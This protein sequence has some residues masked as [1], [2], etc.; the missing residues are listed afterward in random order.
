MSSCHAGS[1][2]SGNSRNSRKPSRSSGRASSKQ[3]VKLINNCQ[4]CKT[5]HF[6][7]QCPAWNKSCAD[8]GRPNVRVHAAIE[9]Q[10]QEQSPEQPRSAS[11][12]QQLPDGSSWTFKYHVPTPTPEQQIH[13]VKALL[14][15]N[16][17]FRSPIANIG[18]NPIK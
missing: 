13:D 17:Q 3:Q 1:G 12:T 5:S 15:E 16:G 14:S 7:R 10:A 6:I 18:I 8:C 4:R 11:N 2:H 9:Q